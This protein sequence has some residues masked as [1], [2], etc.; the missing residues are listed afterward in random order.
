MFEVLT[1]RSPI[2]CMSFR[3]LFIM[4]ARFARNASTLSRTHESQSE[5][6]ATGPA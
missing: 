3:V 1:R 2:V 6:K 5:Y 4:A